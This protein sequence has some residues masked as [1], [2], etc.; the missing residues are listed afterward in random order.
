MEGGFCREGRFN[1]EDIL[2]QGSLNN[3]C[4]IIYHPSQIK[5]I[6]APIPVPIH[7]VYRISRV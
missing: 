6:K 1:T 3:I 7:F 5:V 4:S 2:A